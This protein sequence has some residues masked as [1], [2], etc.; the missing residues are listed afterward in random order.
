MPGTDVGSYGGCSAPDLTLVLVPPDE[1]LETKDPRGGLEVKQAEIGG[2]FWYLGLS[3]GDRLNMLNGA[4]VG[5]GTAGLL[6]GPLEVLW[7]VDLLRGTESYR[8]AY[9]DRSVLASLR[10]GLERAVGDD[11]PKERCRGDMATITVGARYTRANHKSFDRSCSGMVTKRLN[12]FVADVL[13]AAG[14]PK[15]RRLGPLTCEKLAKNPP[16]IA[17]RLEEASR[18][19]QAAASVEVRDI[20]WWKEG[21]IRR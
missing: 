4:R 8:I 11:W 10:A 3:P 7:Q 17:V 15:R 18:V 1:L 13:D 2:R 6:R 9:V 19:H 12:T 14:K 20:D 21:S 5:A 16:V